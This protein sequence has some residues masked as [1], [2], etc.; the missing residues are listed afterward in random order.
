[1]KILLVA[2]QYYPPTLGGSAISS[3]RLAHGLAERG[4]HVSIIAP[5]LSFRHGVERDGNTTVYRCRSVS[6]LLTSPGKKA[7]P[8]FALLPDGMVERTFAK[9]RPDVVHIQT[10]AYIGAIALKVAKKLGIP[11]VA[12]NHAMPE[13]V[14]PFVPFKVNKDWRPYK[15]FETRY[16]EEIIAILDQCDF[17]TAPTNLACDMLFENGLSKQAVPVSNGV[18]LHL[19]K[20]TTP[21]EKRSLK[22]RFN[23]PLDRPIVLYAGRMSVEKRLDVLVEALPKAL[24]RTPFHLVFTGSGPMDVPAMV[25]EAACAAHVTFTGM[26]DE[27]TLPLIYRAADIFVLPSEA[28]L[29]GMVLLEAAAS[30]LPL[31]GANASAIPE[32]VHHGE[33]GFLHVPGSADDL[34]ERIVQLAVD[35]DLRQALG[36]R[37]LELVQHHALRES[38]SQF[39]SIFRDV[40]AESRAASAPL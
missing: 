18:D 9:V 16:W 31:I 40:L 36:R 38:I 27:S 29:Q 23:L 11:V 4:H 35:A 22:E 39:E 30:G 14:L 15:V 33:N 17:V 24:A 2:D 7:P 12:T 13:N 3:R 37:G 10:P 26:V 32:I 8:R 6:P 25:Q 21:E 20:P 34:A 1:M 28:E 5:S 19:F